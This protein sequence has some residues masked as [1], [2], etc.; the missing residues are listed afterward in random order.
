[1]KVK[2]RTPIDGCGLNAVVDLPADR[3]RELVAAG[4][5]VPS[6]KQPTVQVA[7]SPTKKKAPAKKKPI[8]KK[9]AKQAPQTSSVKS[10]DES[11]GDGGEQQ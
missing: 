11:G 7:K 5:A 8:A 3:A 4:K 10:A 2:L 9:P 1:M 6:A